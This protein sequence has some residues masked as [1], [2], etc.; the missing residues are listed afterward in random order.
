MDIRNT[1]LHELAAAL[2]AGKISSAELCRSCLENV[3][4]ADGEVGAF[5]EINRENL[6]NAAA[7]P[8]HGGPKEK[9]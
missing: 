4:K 6:L 5:I 1:T 9:L 7:L 3:D 8:M 2:D